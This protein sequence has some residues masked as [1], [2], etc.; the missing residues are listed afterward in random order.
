MAFLNYHDCPWRATVDLVRGRVPPA[1]L[2]GCLLCLDM[3]PLSD[4]CFHA[5]TG[6]PV[7]GCLVEDDRHARTLEDS[8]FCHLVA[9]SV[10]VTFVYRRCECVSCVA[11]VAVRATE[12]VGVKTS[13]VLGSHVLSSECT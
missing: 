13:N 6:H 7:L 1:S 8:V 9:V 4:A 2:L 12:P 3:L 5:S 10:H 11:I